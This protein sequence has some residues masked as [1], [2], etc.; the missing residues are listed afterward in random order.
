[1]SA[2]SDDHH[3]TESPAFSRRQSS[4]CQSERSCEGLTMDKT[5]Q[6]WRCM[7]ELQEKYGCYHCTRMDLAMDAGDEGVNYMRKSDPP[8][9][10]I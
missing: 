4:A 1:M 5:Q 7:L 8:Y 2:S 9:A 6:L 10:D 3:Q